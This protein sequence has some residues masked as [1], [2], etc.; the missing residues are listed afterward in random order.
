MALSW[1]GIELRPPLLRTSKRKL[2]TYFSLTCKSF[3]IFSAFGF[4][5]H[6]AF[7]ES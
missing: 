5:S 4:L 1:T 2:S 7:V 3:E 6:L